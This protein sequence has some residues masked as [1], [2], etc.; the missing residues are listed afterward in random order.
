MKQYFKETI[1]VSFIP[2]D[3]KAT[4]TH[5]NGML[6]VG[7][8]KEDEA[9]IKQTFSCPEKNIPSFGIG[10][11][12]DSHALNMDISSDLKIAKSLNAVFALTK[13]TEN[14]VINSLSGDQL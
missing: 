4:F 7:P 6:T 2:T 8:V 5:D 10:V 12:I 13:A 3:C 1:P 14:E 11:D 9:W